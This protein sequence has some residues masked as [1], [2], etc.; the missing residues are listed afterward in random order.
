[1]L[2]VKISCTIIIC[3]ASTNLTLIVLAGC[4]GVVKAVSPSSGTTEEFNFVLEDILSFATGATEVPPIGLIPKPAITF[5]EED[6][7]YPLANTCINC[8]KLPM[9]RNADYESFKYN[10]FYGINNTQGFGQVAIAS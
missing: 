5:H 7:F 10:F 6:S 9:R 8:L 2:K 4:D 1:M 3:I